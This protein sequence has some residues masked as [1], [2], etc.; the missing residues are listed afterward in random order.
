MTWGHPEEVNDMPSGFGTSLL[1]GGGLGGGFGE[2]FGSIALGDD[3]FDAPVFRSLGGNFSETASDLASEEESP[4]FRSLGLAPSDVATDA[5]TAEDSWLQTMPPLIR[6]QNALTPSF[7]VP[8]WATD[9]RRFAKED[10]ERR[11]HA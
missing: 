1:G 4:R 6:R 8:C 2:Q 3:D 5:E 11:A 10:A 7:V 9:R